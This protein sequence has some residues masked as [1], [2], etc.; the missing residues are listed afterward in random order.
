MPPEFVCPRFKG[1][2]PK[3]CSR[4]WSGS[5]PSWMPGRK[6]FRAKTT[7]PPSNPRS[8]LNGT[9]VNAGGLHR[10]DARLRAATRAGWRAAPRTSRWAGRS[11]AAGSGAVSGSSL[12]SP[13]AT[14]SVRDRRPRPR[15]QSA[16]SGA[17]ARLRSSS[18]NASIL[19]SASAASSRSCPW[20]SASSKRRLWLSHSCWLHI[21]QSYARQ[22]SRTASR[23]AT[24]G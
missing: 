7:R 24:V 10:T 1:Q 14:H 8:A 6:R 18:T 23:L 21:C 15:T 17:R 20:S 11:A 5:S 4:W 2:R 16:P 19:A 9:S 22:L 12:T 13:Q 3:R